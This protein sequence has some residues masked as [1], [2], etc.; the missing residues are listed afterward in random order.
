MMRL[1]QVGNVLA[2]GTIIACL[3]GPLFAAPPAAAPPTPAGSFRV[4]AGDEI[5]TS[6]QPD[7]LL[8]PF[9]KVSVTVF[10]QK[11]LSVEKTQIDS[12][13]NI[14]LP[15]VGVMSAGGKTA[16]QVSHDIEEK[17]SKYLVQ[18]HVSVLIDEA[19]SQRLTVSGA[20][21]EPGV[22]NLKGRTTLMQAVAMAKGP[23]NKFA[24]LRHVAVFRQMAGHNA[25]AIFDLKAIE[26]GHSPDPEVF[27][28]DSVI[29]EG[30][31]AKSFW[32]ELVAALP[33]LGVFAY[34]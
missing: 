28:G 19:V 14:V 21:T 8:G 27:G 3:A 9:D 16:S 23:D 22:F 6:V 7:Y 18:P 34:F 11:E 30:S 17:L 15:L 2:L 4:A 12:G 31:N 20:V 10:G 26:A 13:G 1:R 32:R 33:G 24:N 29:V 5:P 25:R